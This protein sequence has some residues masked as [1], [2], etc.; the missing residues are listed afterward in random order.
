[1]ATAAPPVLSNLAETLLRR[2]PSLQELIVRL[3]YAEDY[4]WFAELA[5]RLF[6]DEA[7]TMLAVPDVGERL[8]ISPGTSRNATSPST[9][10]TWS[11]SRTRGRTRPSPGCGGASPSS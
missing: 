8:E 4:A 9:P 1:M 6:P 10:P 2:P 3:G 5:R 7:E 11:S